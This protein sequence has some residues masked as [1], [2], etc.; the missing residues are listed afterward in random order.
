MQAGD[1]CLGGLLEQLNELIA[2]KAGALDDPQYQPTS[3]IT[4]VPGHN[5]TAI[6]AGATQN[7]VAA[8]LVVNFE[9]SALQGPDDLT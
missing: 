4:I 7:D 6:V 3:Q 2:G 9:A 8:R 1:T 5:H